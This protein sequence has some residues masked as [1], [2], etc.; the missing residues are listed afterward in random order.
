MNLKK[1]LLKVFSANFV[2]TITSIIVGFIV[3]SILTIEGYANLK[4]YTLYMT[5]VGIMHFGFVDG[6]YLKYGGKDIEKISLAKLKG[7]HF[8]LLVM[9]IIMTSIFLVI[10]WLSHDVV[11]IL[12][13]ISILPANLVSFHKQFY[14]AVGRFNRYSRILNIYSLTYIIFNLSLVFLVKSTSFE[15]YCLTNLVCNTFALLYSEYHFIKLVKNQKMIVSKESLKHIKSGFML[16]S[17]N[18]AAIFLYSIDKWFVKFFFEVKDFSYY[19]FAVSMFNIIVVFLNSVSITFYNVFAK[20]EEKNFIIKVK[21]TLL[22]LGAFASMAY[23]PLAIFLHFFL[24]K[25][26][27]SLTIIALS[28]ATFPYLFIIK[29]IFVNLYKSRKKEKKYTKIVLGML[30]VAC[31]LNGLAMLIYKDIT[32]IALATLLSF[33]IW[34]V[35]S[36][37]DFKYL[38]SDWREVLFLVIITSSFIICSHL[39][40]V[41]I[42]CV[43]Y[44]VVLIVSELAIFRK[45]SWDSFKLK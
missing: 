32:T 4:T 31:S 25:Y 3:P 20:K 12:L 21:D 18:L 6:L 29:A 11:L 39:A 41:I 15:V 26:V 5:Y 24:P 17:G 7:E 1:N 23:F 28:F 30:V 45:L 35:I 14:Q 40:N 2:Q 33:I 9:Q 8:L 43:I 10:S 13:T 37:I 44:L 27:P 42:G 34:Y 36:F 19:S 16:M 22:F 38:K